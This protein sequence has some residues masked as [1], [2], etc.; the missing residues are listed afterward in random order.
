M[1]KAMLAGAGV[2]CGFGILSGE[3]IESPAIGTP[4][5]AG[6]CAIRATVGGISEHY[7]FLSTHLNDVRR[8]L[9]L[10]G[11]EAQAVA[12]VTRACY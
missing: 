3:E 4:A 8:D 5:A 2:G 12:S 7:V 11:Q 9:S 1:Y 6:N 10:M